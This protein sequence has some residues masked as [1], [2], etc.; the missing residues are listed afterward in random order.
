[1]MPPTS[2]HIIAPVPDSTPRA[3]CAPLSHRRSTAHS[4][5]ARLPTCTRLRGFG[6][7]EHHHLRR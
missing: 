1:M 2:I 7:P 5:T 6:T 4:R 3:V